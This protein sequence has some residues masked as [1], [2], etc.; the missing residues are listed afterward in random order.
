MMVDLVQTVHGHITWLDYHIEAVSSPPEE[1]DRN[2]VHEDRMILM[3]E[4]MNMHVLSNIRSFNNQGSLIMYT[5]ANHK[6]EWT[7]NTF[8]VTFKVLGV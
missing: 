3:R 8:L 4:K 1:T 7:H 6:I 5:C 2:M